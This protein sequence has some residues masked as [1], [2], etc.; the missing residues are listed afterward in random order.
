MQQQPGAASGRQQQFD[1]SAPEGNSSS[2]RS[3]NSGA[4]HSD[5][6]EVHQLQQIPSSSRQRDKE[7]AA[8]TTWL[9]MNLHH[10]SL[11]LPCAAELHGT[12][13]LLSVIHGT[14]LTVVTKCMASCRLLPM[15]VLSV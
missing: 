4:A 2:R 8:L 9:R 15:D 1:T 11:W 13:Y 14:S 7:W 12:Q 6:E 3:S 5:D 10:V